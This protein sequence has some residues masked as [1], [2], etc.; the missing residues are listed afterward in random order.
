[1]L[2]LAIALYLMILSWR[3][4][5]S[6]MQSKRFLRAHRWF[7]LLILVLLSG[8]R[9]R[10]SL[11]TVSY[12]QQ[13]E[14]EVVPFNQL[15]LNYF[16][17]ARYQPLWVLLTSICKSFDSFVLLQIIVALI[18]NSAV[19]YFFLRT[20]KKF[21]MAV[22]LYYLTQYFYFNMDIMRE[23]LAVA[24]FL[25]A[26]IQ[27]NQ[28]RFK[29]FYFLIFASSFMHL[30]AFALLMVPF[31]L[32]SRIPDKLKFLIS[33]LGV[34]YLTSLENPINYFASISPFIAS[35]ELENYAIQS[36][37]TL[38]GFL[39]QILRII[40]I[41]LVLFYYRRRTISNLLLNKNLMF[42]LCWIYVFI[43]IL[44]IVSL[45]YID[46][47][48]NY[49]ILPVI[50][51]LVAALADIYEKKSIK[52]YRILLMVFACVISFIFY[53]LPMTKPDP[54]RGYVP[55]YHLYYPYNSVLFPKVDPIREYMIH[56]DGRN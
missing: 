37:L 28:H 54:H 24:F 39:Y 31:V 42:Y 22:L 35:L 16:A 55:G 14:I 33:V 51:C 30:Y 19:F 38:Y 36:N 46:R 20:T 45:P 44:K 1:M 26:I 12:M 6:D 17:E 8:L 7:T 23:S 29:S 2:Y 5:F 41:G 3:Y 11:D 52:K 34:L 27:Y 50:S 48:A 9:Y 4:D 25:I 18:L 10:L 32:S 47:F 56:M 43:V 13:F 49:F 53:V 15:T 40:P 21:F